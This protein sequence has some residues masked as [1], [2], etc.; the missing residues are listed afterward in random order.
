MDVNATT[1]AETK[2][3]TTAATSEEESYGPDI[4]GRE[5]GEET[6]LVLMGLCVLPWFQENIF[7]STSPPNSS[8]VGPGYL[9]VGMCLGVASFI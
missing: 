6:S 8:I 2:T 1:T 7:Y 3:A 5:L 4:V 9:A